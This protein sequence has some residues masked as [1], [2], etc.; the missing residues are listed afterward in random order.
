LRD[1]EQGK[2]SGG[3]RA[4]VLAGVLGALVTACGRAHVQ[5]VE[6]SAPPAM[7]APLP[8]PLSGPLETFQGEVAEVD[9]V[10]GTILVDVQI[11]WAP[12]FKAEP[13]QRQVVAD[14]QTRW[15]PGPS[16]ITDLRVGEAVQVK[17]E[18]APDGTWRARE[19]QL[20]DVD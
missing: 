1:T 2:R 18:G 5:T 8:V 7:T 3:A 20:F 11:V 16:R 15:E 14:S 17:G 10:A 4:L 9:P 19:I 12:T 13:H 6:V